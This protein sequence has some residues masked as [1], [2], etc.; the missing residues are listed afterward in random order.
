MLLLFPFINLKDEAKIDLLFSKYERS[1]APS[2]QGRAGGEVTFFA[3]Y[4]LLCQ[5][6]SI[7]ARLYMKAVL[8]F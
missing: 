4:S 8:M 5:K 3:F 7:F 1:E 6:M 2:L